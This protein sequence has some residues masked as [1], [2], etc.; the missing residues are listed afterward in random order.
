MGATIVKSG[1]ILARACNEPKNSPATPGMPVNK[2]SVH[3][4]AAV[5]RLAD[6]AGATV[7][8]ARMGR[9]GQRGLARPCQACEELLRQ[10]G[11]R[12]V[13]WTIDD[14]SYGVTVL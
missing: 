11:V 12:R 3:A 1:R 9:N 6:G 2:C 5:L 14:H 4:E 8:V 7:Y 10:H 13:I